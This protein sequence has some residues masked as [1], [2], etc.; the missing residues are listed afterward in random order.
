MVKINYILIII[1]FHLIVNGQQ[2]LMKNYNTRNGLPSNEVYFL[3]NDSKGFIWICTDAGLVKYNGNTF[4]CFNSSNGMPDNTIFEIKEDKYGRIW[5]RSFAGKMG[6]V[7]NDSVYSIGAN[8]KIE[9]FIKEGIIGSFAFDEQNNLYLGKENTAQISFLKISPPYNQNCAVEVWKDSTQKKGMNI[10]VFG[11]DEVIYSDSRGANSS[12]PVRVFNSDH[13]LITSFIPFS[14]EKGLYTKISRSK[15]NLY[16]STNQTLTKIDL[17]SKKIISK[18]FQEIIVSTTATEPNNLIIGERKKG[19]AVFSSDLKIQ[20]EDRI[21]EGLTITCATKDYQGGYWY[22]THESGVYY[23]PKRKLYSFAKD[24]TNDFITFLGPYNDSVVCVGYNS[25]T[26]ML[27]SL[28]SGGRTKNTIIYTDE[29]KLLGHVHCITKLPKT[30]LLSGNFGSFEMDQT[31]NKTISV[32]KLDNV[33]VYHKKVT[34]YHDS[35]VFLRIKDITALPKTNIECIQKTYSSEQ[36]LTSMA[37]DSLNDQLYVSGLRGVYKFNFQENLIKKNKV[38]NCRVEDVKAANGILYF[39]SKTEGLII[40]AGNIYDTLNEKKGLLSNI[41]K[42]IVIS[43]ENIWYS[44]NKG[45]DKI[46]YKN[47]NSFEIQNYPLGESMNAPSVEG[48]CTVNDKI[49]FYSGTKIYYFN[50]KINSTYNKFFISSFYANNTLIKT[51]RPIELDH[52]QSNIRINYEALFY[53]CANYINYR[54]KTSKEDTVWKYTNEA[55][56]NFSNIAPGN[57]FIQLEAGNLKGEWVKANQPIAFTVE[58]PYW[59]QVWFVLCLL[60]LLKIMAY[61]LIRYKYKQKLKK[62]IE[63]NSVKIKMQELEIK[64]VKAQMN[65]HF[66]FNALNS[67]Q[68]FILS[69]ENEKAYKYMVKFSKLV[70]MLLESNTK[71]NITLT[72]E[73]ELL[74]KY[75]EIESLRFN[76]A[77]DYTFEVDERLNPETIKIPHMLIQ[78]FIENAIWHGLMHKVGQK[79][80]KVNFNFKEE[81]ILICTVEDNGVGMSNKKTDSFGLNEKKSLG[82]EFIKQRLE[83]IAKTKSIACGLIINDKGD[84]TGTKVEIFIPIF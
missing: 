25:G 45:I 22:S 8:S 16:V 82:L 83:L 6:Y 61:K 84:A 18:Q 47:K 13:K 29:K 46:V 21:L 27:L 10:V 67:I 79:N 52:D 51:G 64:A 33:S 23:L 71:E 54:Y 80:L 2:P 73:I 77:F 78:P 17:V 72:E 5:F 60:V 42:N 38:L 24:E 15:N 65:P 44:S 41:G 63:R 3:L 58:K 11:T 66:I 40:K 31:T 19:L 14:K 49:C 70:R 69:N 81:N 1:F 76:S 55:S 57:Y 68:Q 28:L 30:I 7:S 59:R 56:L 32:F 20:S 9:K 62:I 34:P 4:K 35:L 43:G 39:A 75:V 48:I 50:S 12:Y 53:D 36:R 26:V 74:K 37:Y